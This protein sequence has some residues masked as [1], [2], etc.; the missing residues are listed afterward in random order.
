MGNPICHWELMV[1]DVKKAKAFYGKVFDW[2]F[3]DKGM[4][5][6]TLI[7]PG[8]DPAGGMMA[9]PPQAPGCALSVYF[10][11]EDIE[12][13]LAKATR[14]GAKV[15]VPKTEIPTVGWFATFLD[16]DGICVSIF[17]NA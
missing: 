3:D 8:R 1:N 13:T 10:L 14:A 6:Y 5:G 16:P 2:K 12:K 7:Q 11:V 9:K 15:V 17:R 4:P